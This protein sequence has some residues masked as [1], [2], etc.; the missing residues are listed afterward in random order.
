[1][2][3]TLKKSREFWCASLFVIT[4]IV[5]IILFSVSSGHG[6]D[7]PIIREPT[8]L[9][10]LNLKIFVYD[11]PSRFNFDVLKDIRTN[12]ARF[13]GYLDQ[14]AEH[15]IHK[16][17]LKSPLI[18]SNPDEADLFYVPVYGAAVVSQE[19]HNPEKRG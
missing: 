3:V 12:K 6:F 13:R 7:S 10:K 19:A 14:F 16:Q 18:T 9:E 2:D 11:L 8:P 5:G 15:V 17:I 1:M 4:C